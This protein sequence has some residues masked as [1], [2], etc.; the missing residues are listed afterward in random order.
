MS[1]L[2]YENNQTNAL[3]FSNYETENISETKT[4]N[5]EAIEN[6]KIKYNRHLKRDGGKKRLEIDDSIYC[7]TFICMIKEVN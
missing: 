4:E 1:E 5:N 2:Q 3:N 6:L 7:L